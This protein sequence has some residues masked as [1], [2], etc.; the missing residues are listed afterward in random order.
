MAPIGTL[1]MLSEEATVGAGSSARPSAPSGFSLPAI[2]RPTLPRVLGSIVTLVALAEFGVMLVLDRWGPRGMPD[3]VLGLLDAGLLSLT[4]VGPIWWMLGHP[5]QRAHDALQSQLAQQRSLAGERDMLLR[6]IES[7]GIVSVTDARGKITRV[8]DNFCAVSGYSR[9]D[10]LGSNHR[11]VNSGH[12]PRPFWRDMYRTIM[13]GRPWR[14]RVCNRARDGSLYWVDSTVV[15]S[16]D[17]RGKP[18]CY[19]SLRIDITEKVEQE[20]LLR[21]YAA[22]LAAL[23]RDLASARDAAEA[24]SRAKSEF[25]AN[26]SHEIRTPMNGVLGMLSLLVDTPLDPEQR[27]FAETARSS[28]DSLLTVIN[29]ILDFSKIEAGMLSIEPLPFDLRVTVEEIAELLAARADERGVELVVRYATGTPHRL[30]G[31]PG[32]IR[33]VV[34]NLVGNALKFTERG[35]VLI[36]VDAPEIGENEALVRI[37]VEDT[38]IG[39]PADKLP[40]LF[41]RFQQADGSTTRRFGGTGLGLAIVKQLCGLMGGDIEVTS[42]AGTGSTFTSTLRLAF[43]RSEAPTPLPQS[44]LQGVRALV[45]DDV[46]INRR[47]LLEQLV[48]F[49]MRVDSAPGGGAALAVLRAAAKSNDPFRVALVDHLMPD[50][51]GET[52]GR[53]LRED[54]AFAHL[55]LLLLT[56]SGSR[57]EAR[58]FADAEFDGY[59]V[60]PTRSSLLAEVLA[61]VIGR[62]EDG[63]SGPL[64]TRHF[65]AVDAARE[66][67]G[68]A[69]VA[70]EATCWRVLVAEDNATNQKVAVRILAKLGCHADV[71]A[72]G[73][74]AVELWQKSPYDLVLMDCQMPG[75]DGFE[76]TAEIRRLEAASGRR[77]PIVALTAGVM[78]GDREKCLACGMDDFV[79]KPVDPSALR[80]ALLRALGR[81]EPHMDDRAA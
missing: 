4:I 5:L 80:A 22:S 21:E 32:R 38:G 51:D 8:N 68:G 67:S 19:L 66:A 24:A 70:G 1:G 65:L 79:R 25:L 28:A 73:R 58:R 6:L 30:I 33:Q 71:A 26:M 13:S 34:L 41:D 23:N 10:L 49:G 14:S 15:A 36:A 56:S 72:N 48:S 31:D 81:G 63:C 37:A 78:A 35:H 55:A 47:V 42:A 77:T 60:K 45:V 43:D 39:I 53:T 40:Q 17:G 74:E 57:G 76:A 52:L 9:E 46:E 62:R 12:H 3:L 18:L 50:V 20:R 75:V 64:V 69:S 16:L 29:D 27:D 61:A 2:R 44:S 11:I 7:A 59:L 54:P